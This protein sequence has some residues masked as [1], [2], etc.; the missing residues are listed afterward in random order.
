LFSGD[1]DE[2]FWVDSSDLPKS[3]N[4]RKFYEDFAIVKAD[5]KGKPKRYGC[6]VHFNRLTMS[7]YLNDPKPGE[8]PNVRCD[9]AFEF[10]ALRDIKRGEEL[11]VDSTAYSDH[12]KRKGS[13]KG[14]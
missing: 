4:L 13:K 9:E 11:T 12:A 10:Y 7:W 8:K 2:L 5:A 6:P 14:R 1:S 3:A